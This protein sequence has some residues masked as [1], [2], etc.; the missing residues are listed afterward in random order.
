MEMCCQDMHYRHELRTPKSGQNAPRSLSL[1]PLTMKEACRRGKY[2]FWTQAMSEAGM[3]E[4]VL[5]EE[6]ILAMSPSGKT[7]SI[8]LAET[9]ICQLFLSFVCN[10]Y[11]ILLGF[12]RFILHKK[13]AFI[14]TALLAFVQFSE[15]L[16]GD[17]EQ[18]NCAILEPNLNYSAILLAKMSP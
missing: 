12:I 15:V 10:I 3:G 1:V 14:I 7:Y 17:G 4:A 6:G 18:H 13:K 5:F 16:W 2:D 11:Q 9:P 8:H